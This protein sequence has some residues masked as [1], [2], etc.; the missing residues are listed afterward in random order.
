MGA[1]KTAQTQSSCILVLRRKTR[2]NA[3]IMVCRIRMF[4]WS[5]GLIRYDAPVTLFWALDPKAVK[6]GTV[7]KKGH[8]PQYKIVDF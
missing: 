3:E 5:L 8:G 6:V 1:Q 4:L 2:G 7:K